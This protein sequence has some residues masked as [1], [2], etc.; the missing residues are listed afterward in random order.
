MLMQMSFVLATTDANMEV[1]FEEELD[2]GGGSRTSRDTDPR[3]CRRD[4]LPS[5]RDGY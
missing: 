1:E 5:R 3:D 2:M 4:L